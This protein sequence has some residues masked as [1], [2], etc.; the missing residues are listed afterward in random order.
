LVF[1][2]QISDLGEE[3]FDFFAFAKIKHAGL[4]MVR[5]SIGSKYSLPL[6]LILFQIHSPHVMQN[7]WLT[8]FKQGTL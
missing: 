8:L 3:L 2:F 4:P 1:R 7:S 6:Y 5:K